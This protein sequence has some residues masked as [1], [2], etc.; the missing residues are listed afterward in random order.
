M[1]I[2]RCSAV[3]CNPRNNQNRSVN[4]KAVEL[5]GAPKFHEKGITPTLIKKAEE[6]LFGIYGKQDVVLYAEDDIFGVRAAGST[7]KLMSRPFDSQTS[8][9]FVA[10]VLG[11][12]TD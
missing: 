5:V 1:Q 7:S 9:N 11:V 12:I 4:F 6:K 3:N 8:K 10:Q 2:Q